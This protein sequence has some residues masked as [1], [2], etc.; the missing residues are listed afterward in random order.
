[1]QREDHSFTD[2]LKHVRNE[3]ES[4]Q[5]QIDL[6][7]NRLVL[8]KRHER[9]F[10]LNRDGFRKPRTAV[11]E[12]SKLSA[13]NVN[14]QKIE[15]LNFRNAVEGARFDRNLLSDL[16]ELGET[17]K[18][19]EHPALRCQQ[20]CHAGRVADLED[21]LLTVPDRIRQI[22]FEIAFHRVELGKTLCL[23]FEPDKR[24]EAAGQHALIR[25]FGVDRI[26]A[27]VDDRRQTLGTEQIG[28]RIRDSCHAENCPKRRL[29]CACGK[30]YVAF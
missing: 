1:M 30:T 23:R 16:A 27:D 24:T 26:G 7:E 9:N 13:L 4:T 12:Y 19:V 15:M 29:R 17:R 5:S 14:L 28:E 11:S 10:A 2:F 21:A 18:A 6:S 25:W 22:G 20:A 3:A 8:V